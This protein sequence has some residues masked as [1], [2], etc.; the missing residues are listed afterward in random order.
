MNSIFKPVVALSVIL[1]VSALIASCGG[2]QQPQPVDQTA[3]DFMLR[4]IHGDVIDLNAYKGQMVTLYVNTATECGLTPQFAKLQDLYETYRDQGFTIVGFPSN[5][6]QQEPRTDGEIVTYCSDNFLVEF[7]M[8]KKIN[9]NPPEQHELYTY[10]T[11]PETDP[12][13]AGDITWNFEK[14]LID[15]DGKVVGRFEPSVEPDDPLLI[16][17]IES[18]L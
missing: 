14:F 13:N 11:S 7:P 2:N 17:A 6:F 9:V 8:T 16:H 1:V 5:T 10:L 18:V 4:D 12:E 15:R 3:Y